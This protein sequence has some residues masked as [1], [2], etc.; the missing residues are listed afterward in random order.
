MHASMQLAVQACLGMYACAHGTLSLRH[1][2]VLRGRKQRSRGAFCMVIR[3]VD[4]GG[5]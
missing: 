3:A 1:C 5:K 2:S 4:K